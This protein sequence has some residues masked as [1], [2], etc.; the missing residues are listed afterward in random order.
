MSVQLRDLIAKTRERR[1]TAAQ[2]MAM[3]KPKTLE[4]YRELVG[5]VRALDEIETDIAS[6]LNETQSD[7]IRR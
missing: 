5:Y 6:V 3:G 4:A 7:F 2:D 1:A